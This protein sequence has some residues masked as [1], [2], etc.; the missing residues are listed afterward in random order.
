MKKFKQVYANKFQRMD[1]SVSSAL[2]VHQKMLDRVD[3]LERFVDKSERNIQQVEERVAFSLSK[4]SLHTEEMVGAMEERV[5][6]ML[7]GHKEEV[8]SSID[9]AARE[10]REL[11]SSITEG[12]REELLERERFQQS[13]LE[14]SRRQYDEW[15]ALTKEL[16]RRVDDLDAR[17]VRASGEAISKAD[18]A[19]SRLQGDV[20]DIEARLAGEVRSAVT[21]IRSA[22]ERLARGVDA[23]IQPLSSTARDLEMVRRDVVRLDT[24]RLKMKDLLLSKMTDIDRRMGVYGSE[25]NVRGMMPPLLLLHSL[26]LAPFEFLS[27]IVRGSDRC[28]SLLLQKGGVTAAGQLQMLALSEEEARQ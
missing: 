12:R 5:M 22:E 23:S 17:S 21:E 7:K 15:E 11:L 10:T 28:S 1:E 3:A 13:L 6:L 8:Q 16:R 19:I 9:R 26:R 4:H 27:E 14:E 2:D 18:A 24:E 20:Q 25:R